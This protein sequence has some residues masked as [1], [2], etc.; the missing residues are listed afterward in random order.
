MNESHEMEDI[1]PAAYNLTTA[2]VCALLFFPRRARQMTV[3]GNRVA[4]DPDPTTE[5]YASSQ[6][7]TKFGGSSP[8]TRAAG[9]PLG[10]RTRSDAYPGTGLLLVINLAVAYHLWSRRVRIC[11][12]GC[13]VCLCYSVLLCRRHAL[14]SPPFSVLV[15]AAQR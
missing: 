11:G 8:L 10:L 6:R 5:M 13:C 1:S 4:P 14:R 2:A 3:S 7:A 9:V 12:M 15:V